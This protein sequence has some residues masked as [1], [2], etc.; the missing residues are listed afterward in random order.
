MA[1]SS[2]W[3]GLPVSPTL[4]YLRVSKFCLMQPGRYRGLLTFNRELAPESVKIPGESHRTKVYEYKQRPTQCK[5]CQQYGHTINRCRAEFTMCGK[6][7]AVG[8]RSEVCVAACLKC[9]HCGEP[10]TAWNRKCTENLFQSE[11]SQIMHTLKLQRFDAT[12]LVRRRF[13]NRT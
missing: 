5:K 6:C 4:P 9:C 8:H 2:E 3:T 7:A 10:Y 1:I 13:P 11:V 12:E